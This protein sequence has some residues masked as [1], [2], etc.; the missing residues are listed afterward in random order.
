MKKIM[1]FGTFDIL[2]KGHI[3][4][5]KQAKK[6]G[7]SLIIVVARDDTVKK[8]KKRKPKH[9]EKTRLKAVKP[10]AD[11]AVLGYKAD[12]YKIIEK[13]KPDIIALGY[14]QVSFTKNL[15]KELKK[16]KLKTKIIKL[17]PYK[18]H[19]YKSSLLR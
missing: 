8:I 17:K 2:H 7:D 15:G 5:F 14:D 18:A 13:Y 3:N 12:K 10:Y 16:R 4:K 11:K 1:V 6:H 9:N 19:K